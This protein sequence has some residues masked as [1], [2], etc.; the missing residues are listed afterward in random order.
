MTSTEYRRRMI[1]DLGHKA[2][3]GE[4][5]KFAYSNLGFITVGAMIEQITGEPW[6]L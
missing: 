1:A 4:A 3:A 6:E 2:R 5:G